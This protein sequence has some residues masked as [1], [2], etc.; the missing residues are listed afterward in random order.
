MTFDE[1]RKRQRRLQVRACRRKPGRPLRRHRLPHRR[2]G[3]GAV[4]RRPRLLGHRR[5][6]RRGQD[7][8]DPLRPVEPGADRVVSASPTS[9]P[10][11]LSV[12]FSSAGSS[13]PEGHA[14]TYAWDFGDGVRRRPRTPPH[15]HPPG[16]YKAR[17]TVSDGTNTT[18]S[19]PIAIRPAT[20]RR[21][22]PQA[23]RT[24]HLPRRRRHLVQRDGTD[25][26]DGTL[27]ASAFTWNIDFLHEGT[28]IR[29]RRSP[30]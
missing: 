28:S 13:D 25:P 23:P 10:A 14:L 16:R 24:A 1:S 18:L 12:N 26:E 6:V 11:P 30:A 21:D 8:P 20:R 5:H 9:G 17:L 27:P 7:P 4:L 22:D 2:S 19:T 3:P 15:V 29:G